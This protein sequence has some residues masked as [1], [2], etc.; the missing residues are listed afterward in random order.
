[1]DMEI[2]QGSG[3]VS[4][5]ATKRFPKGLPLTRYIFTLSETM[6]E[7]AETSTLYV[8]A[9]TTSESSYAAILLGPD[10]RFSQPQIGAPR[11]VV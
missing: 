1:M 7:G 4:K 5:F 6:S 3:Y 2:W 10:P 11:Y 9:S 8:I